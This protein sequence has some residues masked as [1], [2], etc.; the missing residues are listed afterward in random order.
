MEHIRKIIAVSL[1]I[2]LF[3]SSS[4]F[5]KSLSGSWCLEEEDVTITF[6]GKDSINVSSTSEDGVNGSGKYEKRDTM[7]VATISSGD[8]KIQMGYQYKWVN[9]STLDTRT[10]FLTVNGDS[11]NTPESSVKMTRCKVASDNK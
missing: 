8:L 3:F 9:D 2:T 6:V 5:S 7:F 1:L 4:L 11:V 10:L